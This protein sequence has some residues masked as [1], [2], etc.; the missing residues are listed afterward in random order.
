MTP[1]VFACWLVGW[2][3]LAFAVIGEPPIQAIEPVTVGGWV[4]RPAGGW[5]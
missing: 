5:L 4:G 1:D 3:W 2:C